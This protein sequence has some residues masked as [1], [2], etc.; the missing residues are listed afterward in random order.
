MEK[1]AR[2]LAKLALSD[3]E[4][5]RYWPSTVAAGLVI[6]A[7]L[8]SDQIESYQRV[9]EVKI[10]EQSNNVSLNLGPVSNFKIRLI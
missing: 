7:S 3:H 1:K 8:E 6:L 5:L 2:Y 10:L 4:H 9:I